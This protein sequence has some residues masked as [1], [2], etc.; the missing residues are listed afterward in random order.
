MSYIAKLII[1]KLDNPNLKLYIYK[2]K[3]EGDINTISKISNL[4][5]VIVV[6][7]TV[8]Q[9]EEYNNKQCFIIYDKPQTTPG[10][11][12]NGPQSNNVPITEYETDINIINKNAA[13]FYNELVLSPLDLKQKDGIVFYY[14]VIGVDEE[15]NQM[16]HLSKISGVLINY[17]S[18][19]DLK[20]EIWSCNDYQNKDSDVWN[21]IITLDYNEINKDISIGNPLR[22]YELQNLGLPVIDTVPK[23]ENCNINTHSLISNTFLLLYVQNPWANNNGDFNYR[24]LKSYKIRN[25]YNDL[26]SDFSVPTYQSRVHVSIDKML[27]YMQT[28]PD[29]ENNIILPDDNNATCFE[30]IRRDGIYYNRSIDRDLPYNQWTIPLENNKRSI[31]SETS[32]QENLNIQISAAVGNTYVFDIYLFDVYGNVSEDS[33]FIFKT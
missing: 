7:Q 21:K 13:T 15:K 26:Y 3:N 23:I 20:R 27:I 9:T 17:V 18:D 2:A 31:Y 1:P 32:I 6:D 28:N 12:Y 11:T 19:T 24:K 8:A 29:D 30:I 25:V 22:P 10:I 16:T 14:A 4:T 33:H 5:P